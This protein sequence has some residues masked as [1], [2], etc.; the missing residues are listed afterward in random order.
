VPQAGGCVA[1]ESGTRE[2]WDFWLEFQKRLVC[3]THDFDT[4][5]D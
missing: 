3:G 2:A 1:M 5:G 4:D